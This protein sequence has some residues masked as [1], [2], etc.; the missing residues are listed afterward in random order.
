MFNYKNLTGMKTNLLRRM[1]AVM[2]AFLVTMFTLPMMAGNKVEINGVSKQL[3]GH[4]VNEVNGYDNAFSIVIYLSQDKKER[5][6]V[7][8]DNDRHATGKYVSI[9]SHQSVVEDQCPWVVRYVRDD[10]FAVQ[11]VGYASYETALFESGAFCVTGNPRGGRFGL[12]LY[13]KITDN[14]K[15]DG[16]AYTFDVDFR[17]EWTAPTPGTLSTG[18]VTD[19]SIALT[20]TPA[21]DNDTPQEDLSYSVEYQKEG[22][23]GWEMTP[24]TKNLTSYV[25]EGLDPASNYRV[26]VRVEDMSGNY[27]RYG[28]VGV[29]TRAAQ[30]VASVKINGESKPL[31][32]P[33][34]VSVYGDDNAFSISYYLSKDKKER[35]DILGNNALHASGEMTY[36][37]RYEPVHEGQTSWII[38][39]VKDGHL[40]VHSS[41]E[42]SFGSALFKTGILVA[43]GGDPR[44]GRY[45]LRF[46]GT[47]TDDKNGDG[48]TYEFDVTFRTEGTKPK[49]G[50]VT[51]GEVTDNSIA[52]SWTHGKDNDTP[53][54]GLQ[55]TVE[56][57]KKGDSGW[58]MHKVGNST[59]YVIKEDVEPNTTYLV[60]LLVMDACGNYTRSEAREV[61]TKKEDF[62]LMIAGTEVTRGNCGD[63]SSIN[64][65]EG[66]ASFDPETYTLYLDGATIN[67]GTTN[68]IFMSGD[69]ELTI[70]VSNNVT[71]SSDES[72]VL[73]LMGNVTINGEGTLNVTAVDSRCGIYM[74]KD[75]VIDRC[76]VI[77]SGDWGIAGE[78]GSAERLIVRA[79]TVKATGGDYAPIADLKSLSLLG[80]RIV[81][82]EGGEYNTTNHYVALDG[83]PWLG[84]V[85]ISPVV[86]QSDLV[87]LKQSNDGNNKAP[88][89]KIIKELTGLGLLE[90]SQLYDNA[91]SVIAENLTLLVADEAAEKLR[92][93][94]AEV[95]VRPHGNPDGIEDILAAPGQKLKGIYTLTGNRLDTPFDK[96]PSGIYIVNGKK[97][98]KK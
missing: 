94:G 38:R 15:G 76:T 29:T 1:M 49:L 12:T 51:L 47:I 40:V 95:E 88:I 32:N 97:V 6:M 36:L 7:M 10:R 73:R 21:T 27:K 30:I 11:T 34:V 98:T 5:L 61:T 85:V 78:N 56:Y 46:W 48:N 58:Y 18:Q 39:Y 44:S 75:L 24:L 69:K 33:Q 23:D 93:L 31:Y 52:L 57:Q 9:K 42:E 79:A 82:P 70:N 50:N 64:G 14:V 72:S 67:G 22:D 26:D 37:N 3:Y 2:A 8:G 55:Y 17:T 68:A 86:Q 59:S 96:L 65:V 60:R 80:C 20:W 53:Q 89:V 45:G 4:V 74:F 92:A 71:L 62:C 90:C 84:T 19:S 43:Y 63:L 28:E 41:G 83:A 16:N 77:A 54:E 13:G 25:I 35:L 66:K 91:P 81:T 87:L